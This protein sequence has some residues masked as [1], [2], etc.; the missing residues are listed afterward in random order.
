MNDLERSYVLSGLIG[1]TGPIWAPMLVSTPMAVGVI[2]G[3]VA[4]AGGEQI[5]GMINGVNRTGKIHWE[6]IGW[7]AIS[8]AAAGAVSMMLFSNANF[9]G[10]YTPHLILGA[11]S[12]GANYLAARYSKSFPVS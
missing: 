4:V 12:A 1:L 7:F 3:A 2:G 9:A 5:S 8:G 10:V 11:S 6:L